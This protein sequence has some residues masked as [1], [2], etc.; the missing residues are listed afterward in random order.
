MMMAPHYY[1]GL[2]Q[3]SHPH[4]HETVLATAERGAELAGYAASFNSVEG[5]TTFY[6]LPSAQA[7]ARWKEQVGPDFRFCFKLPRT[8]SHT[9]YL[10]H[11]DS[12]LLEFMRRLT[13]LGE[14]LGLLWLQLPAAFSPDAL[15]ALKRFLLRLPAG[16]RWAVEVRHPDFFAAGDA[17]KRLTELLA[18][19]GVNRVAFDTR[20]LFEYPGSDPVTRE[21]LA[22]KPRLPLPV[23]ATGASPM[24]RFITPLDWRLANE[25][26]VFWVERVAR[27]IEQGRTPWLFFHTPDNA[28][29]PEL[30]AAFAAQLEARI[31][32]SGFRPWPIAKVKQAGLF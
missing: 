26:I 21:A 31:K 12:D 16:F 32:V 25:Q 5:N 27:W 13:P 17:D 23:S 18:G 24:V 15:P 29:A 19:A 6:G 28:D 8:I 22:S 9:G 30:A 3:W 10:D 4:W 2:P 20:T 7:V 11:A 1:I 14:G